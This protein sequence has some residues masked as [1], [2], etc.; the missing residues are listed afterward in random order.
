[1]H[2]A[3]MV[4]IG[5]LVG[6]AAHLAMPG[7]VG[8]VVMTITLGL[9]GSLLAGFFVRALGFYQGAFDAPG[10]VASAFGALL[11]LFIFRLIVGRRTQTPAR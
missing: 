2:I 1:M 3:W 10:V 9:T 4:L 7:R 6:T 5:L 8:G 11:L